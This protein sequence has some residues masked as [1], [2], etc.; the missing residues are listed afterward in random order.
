MARTSFFTNRE[1]ADIA[2]TE[3]LTLITEGRAPKKVYAGVLNEFS[4]EELVT[5]SLAEI[6][7]NGWNRIAIG[8][9]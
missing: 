1:R 2:W 4:K 3:A 5:I 6:M 9:P 7:I 8:F